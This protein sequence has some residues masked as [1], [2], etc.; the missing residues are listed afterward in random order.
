MTS[1]P[2]PPSI[3]DPTA[4]EAVEVVASDPGGAE[5]R[6]LLGRLDAELAPHYAREHRFGY[7]VERLRQRGVRFFVARLAGIAVGCAGLEPQGRMGELKRMFVLPEARGNGAAD[8]LLDR[9]E[10]EAAAP[11]LDA[12]RLETGDRQ[13][14]AIRF[15]RRRGFRVADPWGDYASSPSSICMERTGL[16]ALP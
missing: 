1:E 11:G 12:I 13:H 6:L 5:A 15:Y 7:S 2:S 16:R 4:A 3:A 9:I 14:A 10:T 8:A